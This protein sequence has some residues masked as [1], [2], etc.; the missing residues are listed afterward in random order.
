[1]YFYIYKTYTN[2]NEQDQLLEVCNNACFPSR[3]DKCFRGLNKK[4]SIIMKVADENIGNLFYW[5][6]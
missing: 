4:I 1:M 5:P 2:E 6:I 3:N